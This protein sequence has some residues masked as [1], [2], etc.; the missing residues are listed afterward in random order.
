MR[1][2]ALLV[3]LVAL[4]APVS[5]MATVTYVNLGT[6]APV[7]S[8]GTYAMT[9]YDM[10][11]QAAIVDGTA[12]TTIPGAPFGSLDVSPGATK[13]TVPASWATWSHGYTGPVFWIHANTGTLS[14]PPGTGAFEFYAE[15]DSFGTMTITATTDT[16]AT[17]GPISVVGDAGATGFGFFASSGEN[18]ASIKIETTDSDFS[19]GE[20]YS[21]ATRTAPVPTL[22]PVGLAVL[23]VGVAGAG[24][25]L[26]KS[27][28]AA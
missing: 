28:I 19:V 20:F 26:L 17:S 15:P 5:A 25:L 22:G 4:I 23:I 6:T 13:Q 24:L 21:N 14:L 8:L 10:T 9:S 3:A 18:I 11:A 12:I 7:G 1:K 27:R 16:G 2:A